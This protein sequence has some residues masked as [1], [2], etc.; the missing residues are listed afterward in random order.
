MT[1]WVM[2]DRGLRFEG[3]EVLFSPIFDWYA[4]DFSF[5]TAG[6]DLCSLTAAYASGQRRLRLEQL[7]R[8]GCPHGFFPYDWSLNAGTRR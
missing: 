8:E 5:W 7:A 1:R 6:Q 3:D 2:D 4:R